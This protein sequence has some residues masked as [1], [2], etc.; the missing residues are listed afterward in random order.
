MFVDFMFINYKG[1]SIFGKM[2]WAISSMVVNFKSSNLLFPTVM[3]LTKNNECI[4]K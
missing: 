3:L 1:T 4:V 2:D